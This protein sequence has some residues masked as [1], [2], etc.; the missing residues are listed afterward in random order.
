M[1]ALPALLLVLASLISLAVLAEAP[2]VT[3]FNP[4]PDEGDL[5]LPMPPI[6]EQ[7]A[8]IVFRPVLAPGKGFWGDRA[9]IVQFGDARGGMFEGLRRTLV[10]G[11]FPTADGWSM[12]LG[13]Y[14]LTKGQFAA[15]MGLDGLA[16]ASGDPADAGLAALQGAALRE[17]LA[18]PLAWVGYR[19]IEEFVYRYNLWLFDADH[20]E[21]ALPLP[22]I[23]D[24]P[25][26]VRLP[27]EDEWEYAARGGKPA[28]DAGTFD[29]ALPFTK[30]ELNNAA[31]HL[32]NAKNR[33]RPI[34]LRAPNPLGLHD[35]Y[36]NVQEVVSG[37][38]RPEVWQ[39]KP[40]GAPVR[41]ASVATP[42]NEVRAS[43]RAELDAFAWDPEAKR[44]IERR[45]F[46]TGTRLA[47]GSNVVV[48]SRTR[49]EL[50]QEYADYRQGLRRETP[51]GQ[52]LA[53]TVGQAA[54]Q[55]GAVEPILARL[56]E[57][58]PDAGDQIASIQAY[59][60][61]ARSR[62]DQAQREG[63]RSLLQ[64]GVRNGVN[65][66]AQI[67]KR[68]RLAG[69]LE[70]AHKLL[71]MSTRYQANVE[72]VEK[73]LAENRAAADEQFGSYLEKTAQLGGF[74]AAYIDYAVA[75]M[76]KK[77]LTGRERKVVEIAARH[78]RAFAEQ[79]VI[80]REAW[81]ADFEETFKAFS[82]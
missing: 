11:S 63:G 12:W 27:T 51:L 35:L 60:D 39:G 73:A 3:P 34:G 68:A 57:R 29:D 76:D 9:R 77:D 22:R 49:R 21:R 48:D 19:D 78:V 67:S 31:W 82:D 4:R 64:D 16:R 40:G 32:G 43:V 44:V 6:G 13:K 50:E 45:A 24:A 72:Q 54:A 59:L 36:G 17:Q 52:T 47:I 74:E 70:S 46:N 5:V 66:S 30:R 26:F 10:S 20:P 42:G 41:G 38:F 1:K 58:Y 79:R 18:M 23:E 33:V 14:E 25:G 37:M 8:E 75:E 71:A 28:L 15:V 80:D 7:A 69:A 56:I 2:P 81:R 53:N 61:G 65:L 55:V 62:L